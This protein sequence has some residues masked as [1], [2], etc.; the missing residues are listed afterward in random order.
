MSWVEKAERRVRVLEFFNGIPF[1]ELSAFLPDEVLFSTT[2][3]DGEDGTERVTGLTI[4]E[5]ETDV[6]SGKILVLDRKNK[7]TIWGKE[8]FSK[9]FEKEFR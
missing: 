2:S 3:F 5:D 1:E 9:E 4:G 6:E 7:L 8:E